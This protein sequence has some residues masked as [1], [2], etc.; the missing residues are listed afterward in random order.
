MG[1]VITDAVDSHKDRRCEDGEDYTRDDLGIIAVRRQGEVTALVLTY[2]IHGTILGIDEYTL[3]KDVSGAIEEK[4]EHSFD[5]EVAVLMINSWGGDVAPNTPNV[6]PPPEQASTLPGGYDE[7]E[8]IGLYV[9]DAVT[10]ALPGVA[11][12]GEPDIRATTYRY[13]IHRDVIYEAPYLFPYDYGGIY[14]TADGNCEEPIHIDDLTDGCIPFP[15]NSPA[16]VQSVVTVGMIAGAHFTTW[17]GESGTRLAEGTMASMQGYQAVGDVLFFGY[18]QDY[19]GYQLEEEDWWQGGYESSGA[20]WGPRQGEYMRD[21]QGEMFGFWLGEIE[22]LSFEQLPPPAA[23]ESAP[24]IW[25]PE[26]AID[27][28][29]IT[30]Q[31]EVTYAPSGVAT[32]TLQG[33]DPFYG[34]P[35]ATLQ[36]DVGGNFA[37]VL[38]PNGV[39]VHSDSY[40]FWVDFVPTPTYEETLDPTPRTFAWTF[41]I[42]L[43]TRAQEFAEPGVEYRFRVVSPSAGGQELELTTESFVVE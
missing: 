36:S 21:R 34:I 11:W 6:V 35:I 1:Y 9:A 43:T 3:S 39:P 5:H 28:G 40:A 18:A 41:S 17:A 38:A 15:E 13:P 4:V 8:Q 19:L 10:D 24:P 27:P 12:T 14:C 23:F 20:M 16:P 29:V 42:P 30:G 26:D 7:M 2:A 25:T 32:F 33:E 31:P 37:D 22:E